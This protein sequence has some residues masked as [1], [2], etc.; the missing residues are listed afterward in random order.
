MKTAFKI[1]K[2]INIIALFFLLLGPYGLAITGFLQV[3]SAILFVLTFPKNKLIYVYFFLVLVF[4]LIWDQ[5]NLD[6]SLVLP[7]FLILFLTFIIYNQN[8]KN[9]NPN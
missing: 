3:I 5:H 1:T 7:I 9:E 8:K 2:I 6:W 4:F